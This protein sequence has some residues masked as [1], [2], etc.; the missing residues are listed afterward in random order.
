VLGRTFDLD[1]LSR[2]H[3]AGSA[4]A[5]LKAE[6]AA[7]QTAGLVDTADASASIHRFHHAII[8]DTAYK[9]LVSDQRRKLHAKTAVLLNMRGVNLARSGGGDSTTLAKIYMGMA[10]I[11]RALPWALDG[12]D[13]QA[14]SIDIAERLADLPTVSW[15]YMASG[16]FEMGKCGWQTGEAHLRRS[17]DVADR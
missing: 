10:L 17:M 1:L 11:S 4:Q 5:V 7:A 15:V 8:G 16:V 9:L 6:I 13:L 14:K 12:T 3:P 2:L